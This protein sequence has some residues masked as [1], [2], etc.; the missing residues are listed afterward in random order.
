MFGQESRGDLR[1]GDPP[2]SLLRMILRLLLGLALCLF[3][4][5]RPEKKS[6]A[7]PVEY[8]PR[9]GDFVFQSLPHNAIID[10]IEGSSGSPFSHCGILKKRDVVK[11]HDS[12]WVVIEAIGPVK[13]TR[14]PFWIAQGRDSAYVVYR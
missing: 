6:A 5:C 4:G 14:L 11:R 1:S 7:A 3:A 9:A 8:E 2:C 12:A 13:E 10:A